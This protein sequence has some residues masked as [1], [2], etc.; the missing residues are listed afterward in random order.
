MKNL[1]RSMCCKSE[2]LR[3]WPQN[4]I[5]TQPLSRTDAFC[6]LMPVEKIMGMYMFVGGLPMIMDMLV[7][8]INSQ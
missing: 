2:I 7:D 1:I 5:A 3:L 8:E 4:D 6:G